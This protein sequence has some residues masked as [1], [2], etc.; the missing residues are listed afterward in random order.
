MA[1]GYAS[2]YMYGCRLYVRLYVWLWVIRPAVCMAVGY[3]SICM[4]GRR[5]YVRL[6]V[7]L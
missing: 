4:Y 6:Y 2:I 1:V 7:W 3:A 5:L